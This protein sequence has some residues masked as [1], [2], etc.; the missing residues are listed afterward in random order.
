MNLLIFVYI[1]E[2]FPKIYEKKYFN[3]PGIT[4]LN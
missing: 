4:K 2:Q 1:Y 3:L